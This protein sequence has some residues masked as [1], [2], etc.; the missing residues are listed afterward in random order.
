MRR[1]W[2]VPLIAVCLFG[3]ES[4]FNNYF[5]GHLILQD[6]IFVPR[7]L[8]FLFIFISIFYDR[9]LG[10]YYAIGFGLVMD[11][12]FTE[13]LGIYLFWYPVIVYAISKLMKVLHN[14]LFIVSLIFLLAVSLLEGGVYLFNYILQI[15]NITVQEFVNNRLF[16]TLL[17]NLCFY[18][19]FS[20]P[21]KKYFMSI[22]KVKEEEEGMFQ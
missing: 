20:Y 4:I 17:L 22:K 5:P 3:I 21:L 15:T 18:I 14:H 10:I 7:F 8:F 11:L 16:P 12:V 9:N 2:W 1:K 6:G 19:I 13:I